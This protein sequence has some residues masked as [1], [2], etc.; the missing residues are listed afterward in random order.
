MKKGSLKIL[1]LSLF[2]FICSCEK[3]TTCETKRQC[4][5]D[6]N[7]GQT[8]VEVPV[9]GTCIDTSFGI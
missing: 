5:S 7:G 6:G 8:C 9:P 2:V 4:Y 3:E 1:L